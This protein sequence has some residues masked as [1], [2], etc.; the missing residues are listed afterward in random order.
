MTLRP[1]MR[2]I[3][4]LGRESWRFAGR[5]ARNLGQGCGLALGRPCPRFAVSV[6]QL[7]AL[8][9]LG[10]AC[11]LLAD[12]RA[13]DGTLRLSAWGIATE[14][15]RAYWWLGALAIVTLLNGRPG[16][17][18]QVTVACAAAE[19]LLWAFW[20]AALFSLP[21]LSAFVA[22]SWQ[23][24]I[25][26]SVFAWQVLILARALRLTHPHFRWRIPA[27]AAC[28]GAGLYASVEYL[29]DQALLVPV[30]STDAGPPLD[31]EGT[32]YAQSGLLGAALEDVAPGRPGVPDFY[33]LGFG[34]YADE[35]VFRREVAQ[36]RRIVGSRLDSSARAV[37]LVNSPGTLQRY[38]LANRS[39]LEYVLHQLARRMELEQD[40]LFLF[41]T[42]HGAETGELV[43]DFG[44]L[45][46]NDL[47]PEELRGM[48]ER[49]GI[50][51]R[52]LVVSACYSG[53][54]V[55]ALQGPRT[56]VITAAASDRS[57]FGCA[58]ENEWTYFGEA[59]F[60]DALAGGSSL[61]E[62]FERARAA[63]EL[64]EAREGKEGSRPQMS[65][66]S[67]IEAHLARWAASR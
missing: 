44:E 12:W 63:I 62:A 26:W 13:A 31:V 43:I 11:A 49:A 6:G 54:F 47:R 45:G 60:R 27:L 66:G 37:T 41:M 35:A 25:W 57:S 10:W 18:L 24:A 36:V 61:T 4:M 17:F 2:A 56:L 9:A 38:P 40:I 15:A 16:S 64:R 20:F 1:G 28:Y 52:V 8:L 42:S 30:G 59:Y 14:A 5:L 22:W 46:L 67:E 58:H 55:P 51:W 34:A 65:M 7:L 53:A 39:N 33:F 3:G 48:L 50:G 23:D 29:P 32:Y 21:A 19:P